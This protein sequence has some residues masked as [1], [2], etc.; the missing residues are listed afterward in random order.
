MEPQGS[1]FTVAGMPKGSRFLG[2][3]KTRASQKSDS[4]KQANLAKLLG[5]YIYLVG[6]IRFKVVTGVQQLW[7]KKYK[8]LKK[9]LGDFSAREQCGL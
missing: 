8:D 6:K 2:G 1:G 7:L 4:A 9:V 3:E 5:D